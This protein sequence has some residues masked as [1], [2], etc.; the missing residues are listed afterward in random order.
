MRTGFAH[1]ATIVMD[2]DS[3]VRAPGAAITVALCG[4]WEHEPPCPI[5]AHHTA[6]DRRGDVVRVRV[7]FAAEAAA[8]ADVRARIDAALARGTLDG[9]DGITTRWRLVDTRPGRPRAAELPHLERLRH[10]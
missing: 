3:D 2:A 5:A 6:A 8:E 7:L 4:H 9:P 1:E 10:G